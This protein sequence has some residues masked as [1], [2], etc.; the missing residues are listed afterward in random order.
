[1]N[2]MD[3]SPKGF[4]TSLGVARRRARSGGVA[5]AALA[6]A[7]GSLAV[8]GGVSG[9]ATKASS[10]KKDAGVVIRYADVEGGDALYF[11]IKSG[12]LNKDLAKYGATAQIVSTFPAEAPALQAMAAGAADMTT[13]SITA[14]EGG[15]AGNA[16]VQV[17]AYEP[18]GVGKVSGEAIVVKANSGITSVKDLVGKTVAVNQA[19]SGEYV[20]DKALSYYHIPESSVHKVYLAVPAGATAFETGQVDAWA[21]F[22]TYIPQAEEQYGAKVLVS[23]NQIGAQ[24]DTVE[25]V[26]TSFAKAHPELVKATYQALATE[27]AALVKNP[28]PYDQFLETTEHLTSAGVIGY[29]NK[30]LQVWQPV[31]PAQ[32]KVFQNVAT[33]FHDE[34]SI[35]V[36][37]DLSDRVFD[38]TKVKA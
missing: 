17:F 29:A 30:T 10:T 2:D 12:L 9:A 6:V 27:S 1:M 3:S 31:G 20:L 18:D 25:V 37:E 19:G 14:T 16:D 7:G 15:L 26:N 33:Y 13:G 5:L 38:V 32:E 34:G 22:S 35:P 11:A 23:G 21:T 8:G 36:Q 28:K 4:R 24:N